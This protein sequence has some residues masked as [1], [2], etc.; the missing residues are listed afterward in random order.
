[1]NSLWLDSDL[2]NPTKRYS[3]IALHS[4]V[5][6][7]SM[8]YNMHKSPALSPLLSRQIISFTEQRISSDKAASSY[9]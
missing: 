7:H 6:L 9:I 3:K 5:S 2:G 1:M 4:L 8:F